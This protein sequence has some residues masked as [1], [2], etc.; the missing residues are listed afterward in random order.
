MIEGA[1]F[2]S[3]YIFYGS[4]FFALIY[5][6]SCRWLFERASG[7][8]LRAAGYR[9]RAVLVGSAANIDAV[10]LALR[11]SSDIDPFGFVSL[12]ESQAGGAAR[13]SARSRTSSA[14]STRS[15]RS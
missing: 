7:A 8:V 5:V 9:R 2:S 10:S 6:S 14:T 3:Y 11:D 12:G 4:L 13:T 15:T 1:E